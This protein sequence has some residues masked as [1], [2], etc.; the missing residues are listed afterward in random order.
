MKVLVRPSIRYSGRR[1]LL[2]RS[3]VSIALLIAIDFDF[4]FLPF[5]IIT[6]L[7]RINDDSRAHSPPPNRLVSE[8]SKT[9]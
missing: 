3:L 6:K 5:Y 4:V 7:C 1:L 2:P 8:K 9:N